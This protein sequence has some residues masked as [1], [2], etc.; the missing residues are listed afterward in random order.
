MQYLF[1]DVVSKSR[2]F[3]T[4]SLS[5]PPGTFKFSDSGVVGQG[6]YSISNSIAEI[7]LKLLIP[8]RS[9]PS[10][11]KATA[12]IT[13][14]PPKRAGSPNASSLSG[15]SGPSGAT[16]PS[17]VPTASGHP[18]ANGPVA[19]AGAPAPSS[20]SSPVGT[21][22]IASQAQPGVILTPEGL[23]NET[24]LLNARGHDYCLK[25]MRSEDSLSKN[26]LKNWEDNSYF[27][28]AYCTNY[29]SFLELQS[30]T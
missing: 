10:K 27:S 6:A 7:G 12:T 3:I 20:P 21:N 14:L 1:V 13:S 19:A 28:L 2:H 11:D 9:S 4:A 8:I 17:S 16:T 23:Q 25:N 15:A 26:L 30:G 5:P 18:G 24:Y 29:L 22:G